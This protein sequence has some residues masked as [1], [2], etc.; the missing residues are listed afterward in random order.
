MSEA[1]RAGAGDDYGDVTGVIL[2]GGASRRMGRDKATLLVHGESLFARVAAALGEV[3]P[4]LLIAG[5]RP[6][7]AAPGLVCHADL[8]PGSALGG[9]YTGLTA[10]STAYMFAAAC[11]LPYPDAR[12][13]RLLLD[14]RHGWDAVVI[15]SARG[16]EPL[17]A[18]YAKSCL[19]PMRRRL[20]TGELGIQALLTEL[21]VCEVTADE[22]FPGWEHSLVNLNTPA[23]LASIRGET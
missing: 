10:V 15:R 2:A 7:L 12:L 9:L 5:E 3:L 6:D 20:E 13:V 21:R 16:W 18:V 4:R 17:F 1:E 11:D 14:R 22:M 23:D 19:E 8:Y